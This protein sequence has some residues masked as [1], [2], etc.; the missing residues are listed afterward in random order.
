MTEY[1]HP[2]VIINLIVFFYALKV[3]TKTTM[4]SVVV[5]SNK[6]LMSFKSLYQFYAV[7]FVL[8]KTVANDINYIVFLYSLVPVLN[9]DFI[10]K[11]GIRKWSVIKADYI[12][13]SEVII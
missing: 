5:S 7:F 11:V 8:P 6:P 2:S 3:E 12:L 10:H 9:K 1:Y 4:H 13:M